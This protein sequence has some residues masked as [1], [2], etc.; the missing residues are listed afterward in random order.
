MSDKDI[1]AIKDAS[2][3]TQEVL[4]ELAD[5]GHEIAGQEK[6]EPEMAKP[7]EPVKTEE[8]KPEEKPADG[9]DKSTDDTEPAQKPNREPKYV[10]VGKHNDERHK[11]Q[12]AERLAAEKD[13]ALKTALA[14]IESLKNQPKA[15]Q[16]QDIRKIAEEQGLDAE[17]TEKFVDIVTKAVS[18]KVLPDD[19]KNDLEAIRAMR[20]EAENAKLTQAQEI[21]FEKE[22]AEIVKQFPDLADRK[23]DL[24]QLAFSENYKNTPLRPLAIEYLHDN[25]PDDPGKKSAEAPTSGGNRTE[26]V[27]FENMTEEQFANLNDEQ[28]DLYDQWATKRGKHR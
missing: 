5:E 25:K 10:P 28:M 22:F 7:A 24:R 19:L 27:D 26:V 13:E 1:Q 9:T 4:K 8:A 14:E 11:R 6:A 12:E 15:E 2:A 18:E 23:E 20:A 3:E 21:G 16:A 17:L